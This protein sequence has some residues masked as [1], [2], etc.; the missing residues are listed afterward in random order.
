MGC[1]SAKDE[2]PWSAF[3][4]GLMHPV[5]VG[6]AVLE[7]GDVLSMLGSQQVRK[8]R[9]QIGTTLV[10]IYLALLGTVLKQSKKTRMYVRNE[11]TAFSRICSLWAAQT[12][13][14]L[15]LER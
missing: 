15:E 14:I 8:I 10:R 6:R 7:A 13:S 9:E 2:T 4:S 5:P 11:R 3:L 1:G 12:T